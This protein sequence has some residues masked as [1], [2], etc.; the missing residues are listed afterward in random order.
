MAYDESLGDE[1]IENRYL[2]LISVAKF[3]NM[4]ENMVNLDSSHLF[5]DRKPLA[6]G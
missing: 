6:A 2:K 1:K 3:D 4:H 5:D